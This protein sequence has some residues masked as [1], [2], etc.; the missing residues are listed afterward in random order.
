MKTNIFQSQNN[1]AYSSAK[2]CSIILH[3]NW[4]QPQ[5]TDHRENISWL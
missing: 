2:R 4:N 5:I 1:P 3:L